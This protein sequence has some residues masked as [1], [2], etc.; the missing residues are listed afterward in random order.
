MN[1]QSGRK[2]SGYP[3]YLTDA[4]AFPPGEIIPVDIEEL[5]AAGKKKL[6]S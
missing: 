5:K 1:Q 2:R 3:K 6:A 4:E